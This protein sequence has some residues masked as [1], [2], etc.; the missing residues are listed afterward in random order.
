VTGLIAAN[1]VVS[2]LGIGNPATI[3]DVEPDE[4]HIAAAKALDRN[5]RKALAGVGVA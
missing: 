3:L 1:L 4:P 2:R 5:L